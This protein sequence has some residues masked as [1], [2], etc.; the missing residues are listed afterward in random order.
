[1]PVTKKSLWCLVLLVIGLLLL[2][3]RNQ[4]QGKFDGSLP[5]NYKSSWMLEGVSVVHSDLKPREKAC[6]EGLAEIKGVFT[7]LIA[8]TW[9]GTIKSV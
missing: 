2:Q 3:F 7:F 4:W 9:D 1:M 6:A 5:E 8:G